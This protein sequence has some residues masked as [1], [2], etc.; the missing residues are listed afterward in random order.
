MLQAGNLNESCVIFAR[1]SFIAGVSRCNACCVVS[2]RFVESQ[3]TNARPVSD[4]LV[5]LA[6]AMI[7]EVLFSLGIVNAASY[8]T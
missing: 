8:S 5:D 2:N 6:S 1:V 4:S 3:S 7:P